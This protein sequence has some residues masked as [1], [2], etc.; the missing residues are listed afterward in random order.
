MAL[1]LDFSGSI[2]CRVRA[3]HVE[4]EFYSTS[5]YCRLNDEFSFSEL[6]G[7][8]ISRLSVLIHFA[9]LQEWRGTENGLKRVTYSRAKHILNTFCFQVFSYIFHTKCDKNTKNW[10]IQRFIQINSLKFVSKTYSCSNGR[11]RSTYFWMT[12]V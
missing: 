3:S 1:I 7:L 6:K 4:L 12:S 10:Q 2:R 5:L 9:S 11:L 8:W